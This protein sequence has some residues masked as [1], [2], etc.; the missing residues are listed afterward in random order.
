MHAIDVNA[1]WRILITH[2]AFYRQRP[3]LMA[4]FVLGFSLGSALLTAITGLNQEAKTRYSHS[5]T[6]IENPVTHIIQPLIG[7][8]HLP[9]ELWLNL[10]KNGFTSAQP[11]LRG[12]LTT[13]TGQTLNIQGINSLLWLQAGTSSQ[14]QK[15]QQELVSRLFD[16]TSTSNSNDADYDDMSFANNVA[17]PSIYS[18]LTTLFVDSQFKQR[19][20]TKTENGDA[21]ANGEVAVNTDEAKLAPVFTLNAQ[22]TQPLI[23][24]VEGIGL[25]AITDLALADHLLGAQGQLSFIELSELTRD[26]VGI[27][28]AL[29]DGQARL[30]QADQQNFDVLSGAFFFNLTALALLGYV[31]AAFLSYNAIKLTLSARKKLLN[32]L[33]LLGCSKKSIQMSLIIE[34]V[35]V[36]VITALIGAWGGYLIANTLVLDVNRTLMGL[37]QLEKALVVNWQWTNVAIGFLLNVCALAFMLISQIKSLKQYR[38]TLFIALLLLTS[39]S[40]LWLFKFA[41]TKFQALLLCFTILV[42]FILLVPRLLNGLSSIRLSASKTG[43]QHPL[44]QWLHGDTKQHISD[45]TIAIVAI[46]VALGSAIGMQIMVTSFSKT[47]NA[48]LEK[49]LS[50]DIYLRTD[51]VTAEFRA[52]LSSQPEVKQVSVYFQSDGEV[53]TLPAKLAS[54]GDSHLDYQHISLTSGKPVNISHFAENGCL[55]NEQASIRFGIKLGDIVLFKQNAIDFPCRISG[56]FYDYGNP[57]MSL[58][59]LE[60]RH[61][62]AKLSGRH[63]GYSIRLAQEDTSVELFSERLINEFNQDSSKILPNKRFKQFANALFEDTFVVTKALNA[64]ILAIALLSLCTSLLSL[65]ANQRKQLVILNHLGVTQRQLLIMKLLQTSIIVVFTVL[66]ALPLGLALGVALLKFVMPIAFGWTIHFH[67]DIPAIIQ[68][69]L[70]LMVAAMVCAYLPLRR[71]AHRHAIRRS[72]SRSPKRLKS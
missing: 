51:K 21:A 14:Q 72:S 65:G 42:W 23:K 45:L 27:I 69:C 49:Q 53:Q 50:A 11:I 70:L 36:S 32:Q 13:T 58:F 48:H 15:Q 26:Q 59:T 43:M 19:L 67:L 34:L 54:F 28:K 25:W 4:L 2:F 33:Y 35:A 3:W 37:Y 39:V 52:M 61:Q 46:L 24:F 47:L 41:D 18:P 55:A 6:L 62:L 63:Y 44:I 17:S 40:F 30:V 60:A 20:A 1:I 9:G 56:F 68:T 31:V 8:E 16:S 5:S 64:F 10:R 12:R 29:I 71:L 22:Q 38:Q 7:Q 57:L 66:F